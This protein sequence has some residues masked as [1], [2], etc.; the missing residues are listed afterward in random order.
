VNELLAALRSPEI[1]ALSAS[2]RGIAYQLEQGL[3]T[4]LS[5]DARA[6]IDA[7]GAR[8]RAGLAAAGVHVGR[9]V[10]YVGALLR[11]ELVTRRAALLRVHEGERSLPKAPR[12]GAV[13]VL[14]EP[15]IEPRIYVALGHPVFGGH[16]VRADILERVAEAIDLGERPDEVRA[17]RWLGCRQ[18][19]AAH[20]VDAI[21]AALPTR[22]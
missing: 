8:D 22:A 15:R 13:S 6:L 2:A 11:P 3:G 9:A 17:S 1:R 14:A 20:V 16:A 7:L 5:S 10:S 12:A 19:D 4:I 18:R 21:A